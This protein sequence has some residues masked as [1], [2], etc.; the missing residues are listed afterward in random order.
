VKRKGGP[1]SEIALFAQK[2]SD[3][4]KGMRDSSKDGCNY[5]KQLGHWYRDCKEKKN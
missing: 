1:S 5:C 4:K 2:Q 3:F